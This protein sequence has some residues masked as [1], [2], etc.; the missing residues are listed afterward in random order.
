MFIIVKSEVNFYCYVDH[1]KPDY[2]FKNEFKA[3]TEYP[4]IINLKV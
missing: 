1:Y 3:S 4:S 2:K